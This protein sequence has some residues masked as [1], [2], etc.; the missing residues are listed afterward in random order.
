MI[1]VWLFY[2]LF[3]YCVNSHMLFAIKINIACKYKLL[4]NF[5]GSFQIL[6]LPVE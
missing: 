5:Y 6:L 1:V 4:I 2:V 3:F